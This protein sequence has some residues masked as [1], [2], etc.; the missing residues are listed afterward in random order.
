MP[1]TFRETALFLCS[2]LLA[3]HVAHATPILDQSATF[4]VVPFFRQS[5]FGV[6]TRYRLAQT[7]HAGV[8]GQL[9]R[10]DLLINKTAGSSHSMTLKFLPT[11]SGVPDSFNPIFQLPID[12]TTIPVRISPSIPQPLTSF[13]VTQYG[14]H[15]VAGIDYAIMLEI[16]GENVWPD[17]G[18]RG[19]R[20]IDQYAGGSAF[21]SEDG[22]PWTPLV[23][24]QAV[25]QHP[26][27]TYVYYPEDLVFA[28]YV[29]PVPEPSSIVLAALALMGLVA[30]W[31]RA[32][33]LSA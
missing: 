8:S 21:N 4:S 31:K 1:L 30:V 2:W 27:W 14:V 15:I 17:L 13:D 25:G 24:I 5:D 11:I 6:T 3:H 28:D 26:N 20:P 33:D 9:A 7:F 16:V 12:S 19:A 18:W 22:G 23:T 32:C 29:I 10:L